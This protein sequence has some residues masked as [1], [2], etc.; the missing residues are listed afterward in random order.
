VNQ[1]TV[2]KEEEEE[3]DDEAEG[4]VA[5]E[6]EEEEEVVRGMEKVRKGREKEDGSDC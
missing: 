2:F 3:E 4:E 1:D 6:E 5:A